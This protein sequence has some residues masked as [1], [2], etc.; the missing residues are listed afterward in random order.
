MT[1]TTT[2]P[3]TNHLSLHPPNPLTDLHAVPESGLILAACEAPEMC[4]YYVP[5]IGPAPKWAGFLDNVTE[6][7]ADDTSAAAKGA[8]SDYKFVDKQELDT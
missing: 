5:E 6:E 2:Q 7:M 4:A 1:L 8:Y 3:T